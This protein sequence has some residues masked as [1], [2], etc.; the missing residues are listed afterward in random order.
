[1]ADRAR[2]QGSLL[3][4]LP[5][6]LLVARRPGRAGQDV[7]GA[8]LLHPVGS[9]EQT[10]HGCPG[11]TADRILVTKPPYWFADPQPGDVVVF[12]GPDTWPSE[13]QASKPTNWFGRAALFLGRPW[14]S[15]RP[16]TGTS[17]S[18]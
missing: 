1:M 11:C 2:K 16:A 18:G 15:R 3:K 14:A 7:P 12:E 8:A 9:M 4:E 6:L 10:L 17:S 13:A 5:V